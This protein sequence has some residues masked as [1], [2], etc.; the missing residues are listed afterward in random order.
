MESI[1]I[2]EFLKSL[3]S[4]VEGYLSD[5]AV[6]SAVNHLCNLKK[7]GLAKGLYWK[8]FETFLEARAMAHLTRA[9]YPIA[10]YRFWNSV[11]NVKVLDEWHLP[12]PDDLGEGLIGPQTSWDDDNIAFRKEKG[13]FKLYTLV[14]LECD[15][16]TIGFSLEN[17]KT[18]A[19]I[20][21]GFEPFEWFD[22]DSDWGG[23]M[24]ASWP[25]SVV[26]PRFDWGELQAARDHAVGLIRENAK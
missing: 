26:D 18:G 11:W 5:R 12:Q 14:G 17:A 15:K 6:N 2:D 22:E 25:I 9:E 24:I 3:P 16:T 7:D 10:L 20:T 13:K 1:N 19:L 21:D 8:E 23:Y 4:S